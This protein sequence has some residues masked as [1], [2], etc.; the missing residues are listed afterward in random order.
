MARAQRRAIHPGLKRNPPQI[1][2][3][4]AARAFRRLAKSSAGT[5]TNSGSS[6]AASSSNAFMRYDSASGEA[7]IK[8][9]S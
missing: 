7:S 4:D 5:V 2:G 3:R 1:D 9:T 6:A 8:A